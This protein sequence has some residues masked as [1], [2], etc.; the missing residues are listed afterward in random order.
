M[1]GRLG[2]TKALPVTNSVRQFG[3]AS[4]RAIE[5]GNESLR[6]TVL[7][8]AGGKIYSIVHKPS[9]QELL[10][11]NPRITPHRTFL[12]D[13]YD[14][15]W[16]GGWD[17][18]FPNDEAAYPDSWN[19]P[20]H[21]E[22]WTEPWDI[23]GSQADDGRSEL[24]LQVFCP[25]SKVTFKKHLSL[26]STESE[27]S[28]RYRLLNQGG[29]VPYLLK[30]HP[31]LA[32]SPGDKIVIPASRYTLEPQFLGTLHDGGLRSDSPRFEQRKRVVDLQSVPVPESRELFF[33]YGTDLHQG[34]VL[35]ESPAKGIDVQLQFPSEIFKTCWLF[36]S[37]GGWNDYFVA[38]PEP[39]NAFPFRLEEA[40]STNRASEL[41]PGEELA[42][43]VKL[44]IQS[45]SDRR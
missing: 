37:Y 25:R 44:L 1:P 31:A 2:R 10:W 45:R 23:Q 22:L 15:H 35:W 16:S 36:A 41:R 21:G 42:F 34:A 24:H 7:P 12:G 4:L 3:T 32:V 30:L 43:E 19:F 5:L 11:H 14:D 8:E 13:S 20:D 26:S 27:L 38:V 39:C 6:V 18:L 29:P 17:D 9:N 40:V 33:C 28:V